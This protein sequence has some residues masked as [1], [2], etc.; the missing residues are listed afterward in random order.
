[1]L[2]RINYLLYINVCCWTK[3]RDSGKS[4]LVLEFHSFKDIW[5]RRSNSALSL[6]G[7]NLQYGEWKRSQTD[8][9]TF[10]SKPA[11]WYKRA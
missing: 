5:D 9:H 8:T 7:Y 1:M 6:Y 2:S 11:R 3:C 4:A 10:P